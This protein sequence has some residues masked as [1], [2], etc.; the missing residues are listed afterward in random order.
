M[1]PQRPISVL[2]VVGS[3]KFGG[4]SRIVVQLARMAK[5]Q[6]WRSA[7]LA[8][9][10][11]YK[12]YIEQN[13]IELMPIDV[14]HREIAPWRDLK[15]VW[16]LFR[17][18]RKNRFTIVHTHTSKGGFLG[19]L[20]AW[21][22][23]VPIIVHTA[24]GFAIHERSP[25]HQKIAY[26]LLERL[27][28]VWCTEIVCVSEFHCEWAARLKMAQE[29]QLGAIP[30]GVPDNALQARAEEPHTCNA[31]KL[32]QHPFTMVTP[33]RLARQKGLE[34]LIAAV[35]LIAQKID[36]PF[37]LLIAGDGPLRSSLEAQVR[38][39]KLGEH[40]SFLGFSNDVTSLL[41]AADLVVLPSEREG[42][43]IALLET[44]SAG[45]AVV[46]TGIGSNREVAAKGEF[47]FLAPPRD[48]GALAEA[49]LACIRNPKRLEEMGKIAR[50]VYENHYTEERMLGRYCSTYARLLEG[51]GF[52]I[53]EMRI[54][55]R[56]V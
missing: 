1:V 11:V 5:S 45:R 29:K 15:D 12:S 34:H 41:A 49:I 31:A 44:I 46:M 56:A 37:Q 40:I 24:H 39:A 32:E 22:A 6:G 42:L 47:A 9:D 43:S 10:P 13:G 55:Q 53:G 28:A 20:A 25:W 52:D 38:D 26:V 7:I 17:F 8:S 18:F 27:A 36:R 3:S 48:P 19:R 54:A 16:R 21:L 30:N 51:A 23:R 50:T 2:Q 33:T 14:A 35:G 4:A